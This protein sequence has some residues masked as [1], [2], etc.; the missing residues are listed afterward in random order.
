MKLVYPS[1]FILY[2]DGSEGYA[3]E[4]PD[5][6]GCV[7]GVVRQKNTSS[8]W[9]T[10]RKWLCWNATRRASN[11]GLQQL[12]NRELKR[13]FGVTTYKAIKRNQCDIASADNQSIRA[14][15]YSCGAD[16]TLQRP[17][18]D[19]GGMTCPLF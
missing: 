2:E 1:V 7:T 15:V 17:D 10:P 3:V 14:A 4:F 13:Q 6:P 16:C 12:K 19:G 9:T 8:S 11:E 18:W 5:L